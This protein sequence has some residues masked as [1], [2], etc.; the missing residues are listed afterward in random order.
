MLVKSKFPTLRAQIEFNHSTGLVVDEPPLITEAVLG[1]AKP[2]PKL[3]FSKA[4][5]GKVIF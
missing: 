3:R 5:V 4:K 2:S 1:I